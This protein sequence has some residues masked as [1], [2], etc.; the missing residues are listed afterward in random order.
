[1]DLVSEAGLRVVSSTLSL[2]SIFA[3]GIVVGSGGRPRMFVV[4]NGAW[5]FWYCCRSRCGHG[6]RHACLCSFPYL[7][8]PFLTLRYPALRT[9]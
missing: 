9:S 8:L 5:L 3:L 2:V 7:S 1:M 6:W 4:V